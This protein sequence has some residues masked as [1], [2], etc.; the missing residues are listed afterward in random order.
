MRKSS[1]SRACWIDVKGQPHDFR[2]RIPADQLPALPHSVYVAAVG[3]AD[4]G[5]AAAIW[6][7]KDV[8]CDYNGNTSVTVT[9][10]CTATPSR[11]IRQV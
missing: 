7:K 10:S 6:R 5:V 11:P 8:G 9:D 2:C 3:G 4:A 1:R